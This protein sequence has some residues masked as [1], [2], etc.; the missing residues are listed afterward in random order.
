[1]RRVVDGIESLGLAGDTIICFASDHGDMG[2]SHGLFRKGVP[3]RE[4]TEVPLAFSCPGL[5]REQVSQLPV[6]L[7]DVAPTL[8]GLA[9]LSIPVEFRGR[10]LSPW[11]LDASG[12]EITSSYSEGGYSRVPWDL[13]RTPEWAFAVDRQSTRPMGLYDMVNDPYQLDN[14]LGSAVAEELMPMLYQ[15]LL[16]WRFKANF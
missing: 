6:S 14:L 16:H 8:L 11:L 1:M 9:G 12:P 5:I 10:D 15:E 13:V 7:T 2:G 3:Y 4:A